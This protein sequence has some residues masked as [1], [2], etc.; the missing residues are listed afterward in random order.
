VVRT[1]LLLAPLALGGCSLLVPLDDLT[2]GS[3]SDGGLQ[4][5]RSS[6]RLDRDSDNC[7]VCGH[8]CGGGDCSQGSCQPVNIRTAENGPVGI[9]VD[10]GGRTDGF[11]YWVNQKRPALRRATKD[12]KGDKS[13]NDETD[14]LQK[15]FDIGVEGPSLYWSDQHVVH[16]KP[17]AGGTGTVPPISTGGGEAGFI[18]VDGPRV[19]VSAVQRQG[20]MPSGVIQDQTSNVYSGTFLVDGL[21]VS[22]TV[23]F[24]IQTMGDRQEIDSGIPNG[25]PLGV[26]FQ[27]ATTNASGL[28]VD[29]DALYWVEDGRRVR[30][31]GR[32]GGTP[33]T[34]FEASQPFGA[35]DIAID[36][37]FIYWTEPDTGLVR[38]LAKPAESAIDSGRP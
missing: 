8:S 3:S 1:L 31:A 18:A 29:D 15:P 13:L 32:H 28:A 21:A 11:V 38:R 17:V 25:A 34:L 20:A 10:G 22:G 35:G 14:F 5:C 33:A 23:L 7:G 30:R 19:F 36:D 4:A 9:F 6:V 12:G 24:W 37:A 2:G 26:M 16:Q 27:T